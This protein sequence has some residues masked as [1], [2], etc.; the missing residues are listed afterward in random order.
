MPIIFG[1]GKPKKF[2]LYV[3]EFYNWSRRFITYM[4]ILQMLYIVEYTIK[5]YKLR[6]L[7]FHEH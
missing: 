4:F 1:K 7:H 6:E 3:T 5:N 2:Q